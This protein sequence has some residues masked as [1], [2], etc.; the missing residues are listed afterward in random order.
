GPFKD[1]GQYVVGPGKPA[2]EPTRR[3]ADIVWR[4]DMIEELGV[5]PHNAT[6]TAPLILG[7]LVYLKTCNGMDRT[8]SSIPYP[9]SPSLIA[10]NRKTGELAGADDAG[11]GPRILHAS[12][13]SP[14]AGKVHGTNLIFFGGG[15]GFCYAVNAEPVMENGERL[16]KKV[17][18]A[19]C[20]PQEYRF[21]F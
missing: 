1:E 19:D 11:I 8:H 5:F 4:Y 6:F 18:W 16:L 12:W 17:W 2:A 7:D 10:V 13:G 14:S 20:N 15:D 21:K 9:Q 3:D